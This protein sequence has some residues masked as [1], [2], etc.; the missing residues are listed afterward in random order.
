M[1][2]T[3]PASIRFDPEKLELIKRKEKLTSAQKVVDFLLDAYWW[4]QKLVLAPA[5]KEVAQSLPYVAAD[6]PK[7]AFEAY[8][9]KIK[10]ATTAF[11][12]NSIGLLMEADLFLRRDEREKLIKMAEN[13]AKSFEIQ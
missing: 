8:E 13:K 7:I 4:N 3:K 2:R 12:I 11:E 6:Q 10:L 9:Q 5:M 1:G